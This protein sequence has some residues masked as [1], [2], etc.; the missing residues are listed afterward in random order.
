M[1]FESTRISFVCPPLPLLDS[2]GR[3][4]TRR[5]ISCPSSRFKNLQ[6]IGTYL[7]RVR[8]MVERQDTYNLFCCFSHIPNTTYGEE[9][10]D[11]GDEH[12]TLGDGTFRWLVTIGPSNL[13]YKCR[14]DCYLEPYLPCRFVSQ[15]GYDQLY[16]CNPNPR[17]GCTEV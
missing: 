11:A 9:F 14:D 4:T 7:A 16:V 5:K 8:R 6:R 12:T 17:L 15:F 1:P 2:A 13:V 3:R 10:R